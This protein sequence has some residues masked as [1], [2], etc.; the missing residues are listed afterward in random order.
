MLESLG[1]AWGNLKVI[2]WE[3]MFSELCKYKEKHGN[4][5]VPGYGRYPENPKPSSWV[6]N[7]KQAYRKGKLSQE[8][9]VKL[10]SLGFV[11]NIEETAW[12]EMFNELVA[13]KKLNGHCN[14]KR[15]RQNYE[16]LGRWVV[17]QREKHQK[18]KLTNHQVEKLESIGFTWKSNSPPTL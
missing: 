13:F 18:G 17:H 7:Q 14:V 5:N 11:W 10:E 15:E 12:E 4:C 6:A 8:Q 2:Y 3:K 9:I 16:S 1:F